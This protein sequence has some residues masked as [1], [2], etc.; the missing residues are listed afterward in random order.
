LGIAFVAGIILGFV[1][2]Y[3]DFQPY[4]L[5][6]YT[7]LLELDMAQV[8]EYRFIGRFC[9]YE[10]YQGDQLIKKEFSLKTHK[11]STLELEK[12]LRSVEENKNI[13]AFMVIIVDNKRSGTEEK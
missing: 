10:L 12:L 3:N 8:K 13:G 7:H 9:S 6:I 4:E 1:S 2:L 5:K 11:I